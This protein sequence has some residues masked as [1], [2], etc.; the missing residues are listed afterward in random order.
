MQRRNELRKNPKIGQH[1]ARIP[2]QVEPIHPNG[3]RTVQQARRLWRTDELQEPWM[4]ELQ[5][6]CRIHIR[7][8]RPVIQRNPIWTARQSR[9]NQR[10]VLRIHRRSASIKW[11]LPSNIR[12]LSRIRGPPLRTRGRPRCQHS[13]NRRLTWHI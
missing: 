8:C 12:N 7:D 9:R 6:K 11:P 2:L 3:R 5:T 13:L 4:M 1:N 10:A